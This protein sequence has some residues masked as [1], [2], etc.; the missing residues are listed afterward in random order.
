[1]SIKK[2]IENKLYEYI[3]KSMPPISQTEKEAIHAGDTWIDGDLFQGNMEWNSFLNQE[4]NTLS[5]EESLFIDNQVNTLIEMINDYEIDKLNDLPKEVWDFLK[6]EKFFS[7]IIPKHYGGLEFS[8]YANSTIVSK[9]A[10]VSCAVA[11]TVMVPNS[12]GPGELLMKY[13]TEEQKDKWLPRLATGEE[14]PCFAL[15]APAAGSDAGAIPDKGIVKEKE[16]N[17]EKV[18]GIELNFSKRYITLAPAA[19]LMGLAFKMYDPEGLLGDKE[20]LGI[21]CALIPTDHEGVDNSNRFF[22]II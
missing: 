18:L 4:D 2:S 15:T 1:M 22:A 13:G 9:I 10:S 16:I 6:K 8:A 3:Q 5:E 21:T 20:E 11:V 17:G 12:L 14:I 7:M 19:T